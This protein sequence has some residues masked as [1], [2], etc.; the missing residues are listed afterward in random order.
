MLHLLLVMQ[1][2]ALAGGTVNSLIADWKAPAWSNVQLANILSDLTL[3]ASLGVDTWDSFHC[4]DRKH[5]F[6]KQAERTGVNLAAAQLVKMV[7]HR[8]RPDGSDNM[9]FYSEHTA[10]TA[11]GPR[12]VFTLPLTFS[13]GYL[14]MAAN[15]HYFTDV[16]VGAGVGLLTGRYIK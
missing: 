13:T 1:L 7:I 9:S 8:E 3:G 14:R 5:C 11:M 15:K 10:L 2:G 12:L 6:I 4:A 16:V